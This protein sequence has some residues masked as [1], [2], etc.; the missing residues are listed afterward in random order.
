MTDQDKIMQFL[1]MNGPSLPSKIGKLLGTDL[2]LASAHLSDLISQG[3]VKVSSLKIGGSPLYYMPGQEHQLS[4]YASGNMNPKDVA[5]LHS[6]QDKKLLR[7]A[8]LPLLDKV[9]LRS[10][11][12]FAIPLQVTV[13]GQ[14]ELFWKWHLCSAQEANELL[15]AYFAPAPR[16]IEPAAEPTLA[17]PSEPE[18]PVQTTLMSSSAPI[19]ENHDPDHLKAVTK[20]KEKVKRKKQEEEFFPEVED[21]CKKLKISI[22]QKETIRKNAE[23]E[24]IIKVP[25]AVGVMTYFCKAKNKAKC[26]EKDLSAAYMQAQIKKLPLL[27]LYTG[28]LTKKAQEMLDSGA[29]ENVMVRKV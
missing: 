16:D 26:D 9:A 12:D 25:S 14:K 3:K 1:R 29:F 27:L 8:Q 18:L 28:E 4:H 13:D 20:L 22:E 11:K 2:L 15:S 7:E 6:L 23:L 24:L 10:L 19:S 21:I 5:V 17:A